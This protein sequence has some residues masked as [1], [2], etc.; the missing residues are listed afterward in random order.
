MR[1]V[2][3]GTPQASEWDFHQYVPMPEP[4]GTF[5][6][7]LAISLRA[8][9]DRP[10]GVPRVHRHCSLRRPHEGYPLCQEVQW[11]LISTNVMT[12][13]LPCA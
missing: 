10:L 12:E 3:D 2:R 9:A 5:R 6:A 11:A 13:S 4:N 8:T 7:S 1:S